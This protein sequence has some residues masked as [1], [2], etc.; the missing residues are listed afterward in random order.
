MSTN[1]Y[2]ANLAPLPGAQADG[3]VPI[4][5]HDGWSFRRAGNAAK[6]VIL[7]AVPTAERGKHW[8]ARLSDEP[9]MS[10]ASLRGHIAAV[11]RSHSGGMV[12]AFSHDHYL[13]IWGGVQN[14]VG[15]EQAA[16]NASGWSYLHICPNTPRPH[17]GEN[18]A[19]RDTT[20]IISLNGLRL[21]VATLEDLNETLAYFG[22]NGLGFTCV[23]H[24]L[25]GF[26]PE[27]VAMLWR[28]AGQRGQSGY[29]WTHDLFT[30]CPSIH[31]LRNEATFC[32]APAASS[33]ACRICNAG[34]ARRGH[35]ERLIAFFEEFRPAVLAPSETLLQFWQKHAKYAFSSVAV[36]PPCTLELELA[37]QKRALEERPLRVAFMGAPIY[38]KGW[39]SFESLAR[40]HAYDPR[41]QF[42]HLGQGVTDVP[43]LVHV[44]AKVDRT[45]RGA[46]IRAAREN[47]IDVVVNW[48]LCFE[49][50]SFVT[51]EA[52]AA[53]VFVVARPESGNIA[54]L[55]NS[56]YQGHGRLVG[57][58]IEL[59]A[60]FESGEI[61]EWVGASKRGYGN[62]VAG[63]GVADIVCAGSVNV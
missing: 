14:C 23:V 28:S 61:L 31:L 8:P 35:E 30:L 3:G 54:A 36:V 58:E 29:F 40:W 15:D 19:A 24:H 62:L 13:T 2:A 53:G 48:S 18:T 46:M 38:H 63:R 44:E 22:T 32:G 57:S 27:H 10:Q 33:T 16:M 5:V 1:L 17:L 56:R 45:D 25:L 21:G 43:N 26:A 50:F 37:P 9:V 52:L 59:Q 55:L 4:H 47:E 12:L 39:F 11:N 20:Y 42:F 34:V 51:H 6:D 41:Y 7:Q 49:S 60:S